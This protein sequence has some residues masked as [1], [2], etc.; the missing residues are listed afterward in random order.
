M[1]HNR[2]ERGQRQPIAFEYSHTGLTSRWRL[3][4]IFS[5]VD[6]LKNVYR[7][8]IHLH[9]NVGMKRAKTQA[10]I[11]VFCCFE[12]NQLCGNISQNLQLCRMTSMTLNIWRKRYNKKIN[13]IIW[14]T[15]GIR[16]CPWGDIVMPVVTLGF[17]K[18]WYAIIFDL[19]IHAWFSTESVSLPHRRQ[20]GSMNWGNLG[21]GVLTVTSD[22]SVLYCIYS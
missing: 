4:S 13:H 12:N 19:S 2:A 5:V 15:S 11:V 8:K 17:G 10:Q 22:I 16:S 1:Q 9:D 20:D 3:S 21:S 14:W 7:L 18:S 6:K